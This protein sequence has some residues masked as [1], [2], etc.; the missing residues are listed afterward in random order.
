MDINIKNMVCQRC[1]MVVSQIFSEAGI[2]VEN[3]Q[4]GKVTTTEVL[5]DETVKQVNQQLKRVGFEIINDA[6]SRLI[7]K[8][9]NASIDYVYQHSGEHEENFSDYLTGKLNLDYPYLSTLFSS[10]EGTTIE[11]HLINLKIERVKELLV[12]DEKTLSEIAWELGYSSVAHLSGQFKKVT[13]FT[14]SYYK[15]LGEQKRKSIDKV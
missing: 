14:P 2:E 11:K 3:V 10:I 7:E 15:K 1:V 9:R 4:L 5:R 12:Y 8:I 6:K 13:G